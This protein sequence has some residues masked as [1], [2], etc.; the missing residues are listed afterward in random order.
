MNEH[1]WLV[2]GLTAALWAGS[3]PAQAADI[4]LAFDLPPTSPDTFQGRSV[5]PPAAPE[6]LSFQLPGET[7]QP[8]AAPV[9]EIA[10]VGAKEQP[11]ALPLAPDTSA[12]LPVPPGDP[13]QIAA[14]A[15]LPP[16]PEP[17]PGGVASTT[18]QSATLPPPRTDAVT[19]PASSEQAVAPTLSP[20]QPSPQV[21]IPPAAPSPD[22]F[23]GGASSLVARAVGSAEG[24]RTPAGLRTAAYYG[25]VDP[26]NGAWNL[27]S[28]SYQHGAPSPEI[29]DEQQLRR[30][31]VQAAILRQQ[32]AAQ[33]LTLSLAEELNGIDL[34]NQAPAAALDRGYIDW[35]SQARHLGMTGDEAIVWARTRA[36]LDP[37]SGQ[38]NAPGL[39]N[40][41][42]GIA[43]DQERRQRAIATAIAAAGLPQPPLA[44]TTPTPVAPPEKDLSSPGEAMATYL[45][46]LDLT[47]P[48]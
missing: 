24:T 17:G 34:A 20:E 45:L 47:A 13:P 36:F 41:A 6:S 10:S 2:A 42:Y 26:G 48:P 25:H 30:L 27:G 37:D 14:A 23:S 3:D 44:A 21:A 31:Q 28:F 22:L 7:A 43:Q 5:S 4:L 35:L 8:V 32:A 19:V 46:S 1:I 9:P 38:W 16:P 18:P 15:P 12:R 33:G 40:T 29:A 11:T 39:G